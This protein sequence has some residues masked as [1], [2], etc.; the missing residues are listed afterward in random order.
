MC[1]ALRNNVYV[2]IPHALCLSSL[3]QMQSL[4][5]RLLYVGIWALETA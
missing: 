3:V 5:V 2:Y 1:N 4:L